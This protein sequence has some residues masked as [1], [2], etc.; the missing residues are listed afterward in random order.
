MFFTTAA[1]FV[2]WMLFREPSVA[3]DQETLRKIPYRFF[4]LFWVVYYLINRKDKSIVSDE[5]DRLIAARRVEAG[6]V[7]LA[8]MM[9][10]TATV[11]GLD[12]YRGFV[13]SRSPEWIEGYV[14]LLLMISI[15]VSSAA[16]VMHYLRDR[17]GDDG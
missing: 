16:G 4:L 8:L 9:L 2:S 1:A 15:S 13:L 7:S 5:R 14:V 10:F 17:V 12:S 3:V 11:A 6:Y